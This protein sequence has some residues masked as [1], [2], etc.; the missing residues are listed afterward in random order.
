VKTGSG[1]PGTGFGRRVYANPAPV[2]A[3]AGAGNVPAAPEG[4]FF[5]RER[6]CVHIIHGIVIVKK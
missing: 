1:L 3:K 4:A 2:R 5:I 6:T